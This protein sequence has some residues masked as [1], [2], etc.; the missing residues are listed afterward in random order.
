MDE[1]ERRKKIKKKISEF[2]S[3]T[4]K[5]IE[6]LA[7]IETAQLE[8]SPEDRTAAQEEIIPVLEEVL[9]ELKRQRRNE[10]S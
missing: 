7:K 1:R 9:Q 3:E 2:V 4:V 5:E 10:E 8:P 6:R